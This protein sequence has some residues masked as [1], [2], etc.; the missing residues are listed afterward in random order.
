M[1]TPSQAESPNLFRSSFCNNQPS[2]AKVGAD[3]DAFLEATDTPMNMAYLIRLALEELGTNI[4]KYAYPHDGQVYESE[5][6]LDLSNPPVL[7]IKDAG[8]PFNPLK[9]APAPDL[10]SAIEDRPIGGLGLHM[11]IQSGIQLEYARTDKHNMLTATF[12]VKAN[13]ADGRPAR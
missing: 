5:C 8:K 4:V 2:L 9:D 10:E 7:K 12:P 11:L 1:T 3:L 6:S 13:E